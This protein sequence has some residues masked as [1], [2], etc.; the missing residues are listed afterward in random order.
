MYRLFLLTFARYN[1]VKSNNA[2]SNQRYSKNFLR[3][4]CYTDS[5]SR[6]T[7]KHSSFQT[8]G[9]WD[10]F[11]SEMA[12][13][14]HLAITLPERV[15]NP[16]TH[17]LCRALNLLVSHQSCFPFIHI[18]ILHVFCGFQSFCFLF[19]FSSFFDFLRVSNSV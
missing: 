19:K 7:S 16:A 9:C 14:C 12:F 15:T 13:R 4:S 3:C 8:V 17:W 10:S 11:H 18:T 2:G 6:G 5:L 1:I